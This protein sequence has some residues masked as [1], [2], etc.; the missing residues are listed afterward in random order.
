MGSVGAAKVLVLF[1]FAS[2][3]ALW[4]DTFS[5]SGGFGDRSSFVSFRKGDQCLA[6]EFASGAPFRAVV[7]LRLLSKYMSCLITEPDQNKALV[8]ETSHSLVYVR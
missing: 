1:P 4:R 5:H 6:A 7:A 8:C 3:G 2:C